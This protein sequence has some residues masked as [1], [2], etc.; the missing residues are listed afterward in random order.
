MRY[1]PELF[2]D[3]HNLT[4]D[5]I[6]S[7]VLERDNSNYGFICPE[8]QNGS[9][10]SKSRG[11]RESSKNKGHYACYSGNHQGPKNLDLINMLQLKE[12]LTFSEAIQKACN[13][14]GLDL[15]L[16]VYPENNHNAAEEPPK[17][18]HISK[19]SPEHD[20]HI[21]KDKKVENEQKNGQIQEMENK[22][23]AEP[24]KIGW[25]KVFA[26]NFQIFGDLIAEAQQN[27]NDPRAVAYLN[28]RGISL[29]TAKK[30]G[31]GYFKHKDFSNLVEN[32]QK[33]NYIS[34]AIIFPNHAASFA[35]R[36]ITKATDA[37]FKY[38]KSSDNRLSENDFPFLLKM[39][40]EDNLNK[41]ELGNYEV[42]EPIFLVEGQIDALSFLEIGAHAVALN[43]VGNMD[44]F[45][46]AYKTYNF[47]RP[48]IVMLDNDK[49]ANPR[50]KEKEQQYVDQLNKNGIK[51]IKAD[52]HTEQEYYFHQ[53]IKDANDY[54]ITAPISFAEKIEK[55][56]YSFIQNF[57]SSLN[58][59]H[60]DKFYLKLRESKDRIKTGFSQLDSEE[61]LDG[62]LTEG[63]YTLG[64]LSSLGKTTFA[65]QIAD[66]IAATGQ[67][68]IYISLE[69][70]SDTLR[71]KS[72][73]R[74]TAR[75]IIENGALKQGTGNLLYN[76][77]AKTQSQISKIFK[78]NSLATKQEI[79]HVEQA[80]ENYFKD[81]G[82]N[83][84]LIEPNGL[85]NAD[86]IEKLIKTHKNITGRTPVIFI[87]Y[88]QL[89]N[90]PKSESKFRGNMTDKQKVDLNIIKLKE[91]I[92]KYQVAIFAISSINR[93][94]YHQE[95][96]LS[97]LKE[98][99]I[100]EFSSEVVFAIDRKDVKTK[101]DLPKVLQEES[102]TNIKNLRLRILKNRNG[103][104][105]GEIFFEFYPM[106][107]YF[108]EISEP[109]TF[110]PQQSYEPQTFPV[111]G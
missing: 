47:E 7:Q 50:I 83:L 35:Y 10:K 19:K 75:E 108:R 88:I 38:L 94:S 20:K 91:L 103:K 81:T 60:I 27:L 80:I 31:L 23:A 11:I 92:T 12:N 49:H 101:D 43:G 30:A 105:G 106:F 109:Q 74:Y 53:N 39:L 95:L 24:P 8:C 34:D 90:V 82:E 48:V 110:R 79:R 107:N 93:D 37:K 77:L 100:L 63:L 9:H 14:L 57:Y 86:N 42:Q 68:V 22:Q 62:G 1:K 3:I 28:G 111:L 64:A 44:Q 52:L 55:L 13:L 18:A 65:L 29:G 6:V 69:M 72:V 73:S 17:N 33:Y 67:D 26:G 36:P 76:K 15:S 61:F 85:F 102:R 70:S 84:R 41:K 32:D 2:E 96:T 89:L 25:E 98:S 66:Q 87:D 46:D 40:I 4:N 45:I 5:F 58:K 21:K 56:K 71:E 59:S 104:A 51:A 54:L 99:G 97:S 16:Y 78:Y